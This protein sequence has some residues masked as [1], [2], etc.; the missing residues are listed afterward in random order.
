MTVFFKV[1][2]HGPQL[3]AHIELVADD[4]HV[5]LPAVQGSEQHR[6]NWDH[7]ENVMFYITFTLSPS[8]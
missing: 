3:G 1:A 5:V 8:D 2:H 7:L 4:A 6:H